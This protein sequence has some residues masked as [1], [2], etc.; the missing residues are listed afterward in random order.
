[1][2]K[3]I[4]YPAFRNFAY[5]NDRICVK[6]IRGIAL[7]FFGLG[8]KEMYAEDTELGLFLAEKGIILITSEF[9]D[10]YGLCDRV[11]IMFNGKIIK[12]AY[13]P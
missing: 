13:R 9:T 8:G 5:S 10:L 3:L 1:M 7:S 6:P 12:V 11:L 2:E 4:T